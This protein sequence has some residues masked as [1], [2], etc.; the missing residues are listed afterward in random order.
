MFTNTILKFKNMLDEPNQC[1]LLHRANST[2]HSFVGL[3]Y[4]GCQEQSLKSFEAAG[5][6]EK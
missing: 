6:E 4:R 2:A 1:G 5:N 3:A